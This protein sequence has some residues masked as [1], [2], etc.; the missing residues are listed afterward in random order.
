MIKYLKPVLYVIVICLGLTYLIYLF[1][2]KKIEKDVYKYA[3]IGN[4]ILEEEDEKLEE[5]RN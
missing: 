5:S 3:K 2:I 4:I 1:F